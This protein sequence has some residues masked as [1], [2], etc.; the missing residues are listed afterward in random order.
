MKINDQ[1][2]RRGYKNACALS[3]LLLV[4]FGC[5][6]NRHKDAP[7]TGT[8]VGASARQVRP[9]IVE[10]GALTETHTFP[11]VLKEG[12]AAK[13]SFRV[14]GKLD[15]FSVVPGRRFEKGELVASLDPR[16]YQ[17]VVD[18]AKEALN[19]AR[20]GLKAMETGARP[21]DLATAE[22]AYDAAKSQRETAEKQFKRMESLRQDE[23]VSVMQYDL[24]KS[25]Y[26][27]AVATE[28]AAEK[29]LE[30][31]KVG[32][33][34]EEIEMIKSRIAGLEIDLQLAENKLADT[35]LYAPFAGIV[36]EKFYEDHETVAPGMAVL[37]LVD[38]KSFEGE[39]GITEELALRL[40]DVEKIECQFEALPGKT[41]DATIKETST[42]VQKDTRTYLMT[43]GVNATEADGALLGMV[44]T[45]RIDFKISDGTIYVPTS[46]LVVG[47]DETGAPSSSA[48][49]VWLIDAS[50]K[51]ISRR[52]VG[53]GDSADDRTRI[54]SGL[55]GGEMIVGAGAR[56]L[57]DGQEISLQEAQ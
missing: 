45:A 25:A 44:G 47:T 41:F 31:A 49:H 43:I 50:A 33:R 13:L 15:G 2:K 24:A 34:E 4:F 18:R 29:T 46:S 19:E 42:T 56:F 16:D 27:T 36:S 6:C 26:D 22:A 57:S 7:A 30:K 5:S 38:D 32:A 51:T 8:S 9:F 40:K 54:I 52:A 21:E 48:T 37:T 3:L 35:K 14:A 11:V 23:A 39:L 17:L 28:R 1:K 10:K 53:V 55:E 20:A 12:V